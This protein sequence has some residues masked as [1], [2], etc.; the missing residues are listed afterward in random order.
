V[1]QSTSAVY[2]LVRS[3]ILAGHYA[4]GEHL[5][6]GQI[7]DELGVSRTP[8]RAALARLGEEGLI[9]T[10]PNRGAFVAQWTRADIEEVFELRTLL[11]SRAAALAAQRR[12]DDECVELK[13][14]V[15]EMD[16]LA[17]ARN[18]DYKD[19]LHH[20]NREF[21]SLILSSA[22]SPRL[23]RIAEQLADTSVTAGTYFYYSDDD[24]ARS[25]HFH[26]DIADAILHQNSSV[27]ADLMAAHLGVA[28]VAFAARRFE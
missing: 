23:Y 17:R 28:C 4:P 3:R 15:D 5:T 7:C 1:A 10:E 11:E 22:R 8:V 21:H 14:S 25:L 13:K 6:E 20:N 26:R 27:A 24:I 19:D 18:A 2:E 12:S 9:I 16:R